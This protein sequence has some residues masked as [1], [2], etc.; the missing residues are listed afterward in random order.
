M[1]AVG[2]PAA[3][4]S[5]WGLRWRALRG[6]LARGALSITGFILAWQALV[7]IF[8]PNPILFPSPGAVWAQFLEVTR[9]GLLWPAVASS[10]VAMGIGLGLAVVIGVVL[11]VTTGAFSVLEAVFSPYLWALFAT[12]GIA[13]IPIAVL[14]LG[15]DLEVKVALVFLKAVIPMILSCQ[16]G[17]KTVDETAI[18]AARA[19]GASRRRLLVQVVAPATLPF[20]GSG[21]RNGISRG[22]VGLLVVEMSV[23]TGGL[24]TEVM[25]AM[26]SFNT[27]RMF[28]FIGVL[29]VGALLLI[30]LARG[31]ERYLSRWRE[32]AAV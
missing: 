13:L 17:V 3:A 29:V 25:R 14:V 27:A 9:E 23:G 22:F 18:R 24:G 20:I 30:G 11:G 1:S 10:A 8:Q 31:F 4:P 6:S 28:A 12:P 19:F 7:W 2:L 16:E 26:R 21:V 15:I 5:A 32:E